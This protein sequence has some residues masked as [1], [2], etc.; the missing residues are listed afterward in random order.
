V[1]AAINDLPEREFVAMTA[2]GQAVQPQGLT[3]RMRDWTKAAGLPPGYTL[4][5]LRK[6]LG[7]ALAEH[8]AT[9]RELMDMLGH[10][11]MA[12][13]ELYS[14]DA[15]QVHMAAPAWKADELAPE[16]R[17][18]RRWEHTAK[19]VSHL[20]RKY[21]INLSVVGPLGSATTPRFQGC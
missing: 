6:T 19:P 17:L 16:A 13:S 8:G 21:L 12:H 18:A 14:R 5:G 1:L 10:D 7:K 15:D 4:H 2:V 11:N 20:S 3:V 9:T